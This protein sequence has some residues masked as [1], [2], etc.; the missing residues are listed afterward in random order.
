MTE[1]TVVPEHVH[2]NIQAIGDLRDA[3]ERS[4]P[5]GQRAVEALTTRLGRPW[6]LYAL[7]TMLIGWV[8]YNVFAHA[9]GAATFDPP[10][11][12][13]LQGIVGIYAALMT[14]MILITQNRQ[15]A[16][17]QRNAH[18]DLQVNILAEQRTA[19]IVALLEELRRDLPNVRDRVDPIA[20]ALQHALHPHAIN[21]ALDE[22][23][24]IAADSRADQ[25]SVR[26]NDDG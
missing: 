22:H 21:S 15:A 7:V 26:S 16:Y 1:E 12:F 24:A 20:E 25:A 11:F 13:T 18:L 5:A 14:T 19:K 2:H 6:T 3:A 10:P 8:G 4:L 9:F 17:A 23:D